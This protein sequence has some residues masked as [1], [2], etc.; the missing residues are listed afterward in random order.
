MKRLLLF[1]VL[2]FA[3]GAVQGQ[4]TTLHEQIQQFEQE[5]ADGSVD[6]TKMLKNYIDLIT[7]YSPID[8]SKTHFYFHKA[9]A[10]AQERQLL[11]WESDYWRRMG[12]VYLDL[13]KIDSAHYCIDRAIELIDGQGFLYEESVNYRAKGNVLFKGNEYE[14][15]LEAY[16]AAMEINEKDKAEKLEKQQNVINNIAVEASCLNYISK[17]YIQLLNYETAIQYAV[18]AA[19]L[20]ISNPSNR[21]VLQQIE[22]LGDL[23]DLYMITKQPEKAL[24]LLTNCYKLASALKY[25]PEMVYGL[26]RLSN[27]HSTEYKDFNQALSLAKEALQIAEKAEMPNLICFAERTLMKVYFALKDY[28]T[29][30]RYAEQALLK[31]EADDWDSLNEVYGNLIMIHAL[32]G[33]VSQ[34]ETYLK[35]YN[36]VTAKISDKNLHNSLQEMEV[37][38]DVQ[39]KEFEIARQQSEISR[40]KTQQYIYM[41]GLL[42][43]GL[44]LVMLIYIVTLR[45]RRNRELSEMNAIK[46]KFFSIISHDLKNPAVAQRDALQILTENADKWEA[47]ALSNYH[48]KLLKSAEGLVDLLKNLLNWAQIQTGRKTYNPL[49]FNLVDALKSDLNLIKNMAE[50]KGVGFDAQIPSTAVITGDRNMIT[51][52]VR[53]LL[54]NAVKFTATGGKIVLNISTDTGVSQYAPTTV[55]ITDTGTGMTSEQIQN[56]FRIDR[57]Q[58]REGTAGEQGSGLGLIVCRELLQKHGSTLHVESEEGKGSRFW[59]ELRTS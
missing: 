22:I 54:A 9:V 4:Q 37:K 39:K 56:L 46:D 55:S 15:A 5:I 57:H 41:G 8:I 36:E 21:T 24:H 48:R 10:F 53:N 7:Y 35:K 28:K 20:L 26:C 45:N 32:L 23:S 27:F 51:T 52:V 34:S 17:I 30:C 6:E 29:A 12:L 40:Q 3:A 16:I 58:S 2:M 47:A 13:G 44:L 50:H 19:N 25:L 11:D 31:I 49:T 42:V 18:R 43:A 33:D 59:F 38:F 14:K 1:A